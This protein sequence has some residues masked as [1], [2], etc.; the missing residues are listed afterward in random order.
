MNA[1]LDLPG[2][3]ISATNIEAVK[4]INDTER[5]DG[6]IHAEMIALEFSY[7]SVSALFQYFIMRKTCKL[8]NVSF[9]HRPTG[10][11]RQ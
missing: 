8:L 2:Q 5:N 4:V 7:D 3:A 11:F 10:P 6:K 9:F 1:R